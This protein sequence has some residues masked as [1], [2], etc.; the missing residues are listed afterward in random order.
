MSQHENR[1]EVVDNDIAE[2]P[3]TENRDADRFDTLDTAADALV[4][5]DANPTDEYPDTNTEETSSDDETA[6]GEDFEDGDEVEVILGDGATV[7]LGELKKG[8]FRQKDYTHKTEALAKERQAV[9]ALREDYGRYRAS[10]E[11]VQQRVLAFLQS[12]VPP[13]PDPTLAQSNPNE[14]QYQ[15]ALRN[16]ALGELQQFYATNDAVGDNVSQV[17]AAEIER[18][19]SQEN[20]K[21]LAAMP[22]LKEPGRKAAFDGANRKTALA[23]GFS[24]AEIDTT[25]DHRILQLVHY[26]RLGKQAEHNRKHAKRRLAEKPSRGT[27]AA[28]AASKPNKNRDAMRRLQQTGTLEDA[29][30]VDFE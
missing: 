5:D 13:E 24:E 7:A 21:L 8:Y 26:A 14:Y 2:S 30:Q 29:M 9:E 27:R 4:T 20:D 25:A 12:A 16:H 28:L 1:D 22:A 15:L 19:R 23:F 6:N 18:Y 10:I 17:D 11:D 3:D